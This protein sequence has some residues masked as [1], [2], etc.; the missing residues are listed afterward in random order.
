VYA[1]IHIHTGNEYM[2]TIFVYIHLFGCTVFFHIHST[3]IHSTYS[4]QYISNPSHVNEQ[5]FLASLSLDILT[6]WRAHTLKGPPYSPPKKFSI[7]ETKTT[8]QCFTDYQPR[9]KNSLAGSSE[10][11]QVI[12]T[13]W[14]KS[15]LYSGQVQLSSPF[16]HGPKSWPSSTRRVWI[17][18]LRKV[19]GLS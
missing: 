11:H 14:I 6:R 12:Q 4:I 16:L 13:P 17:K 10:T 9:M 1:Y 18:P 3:Y 15:V 2:I 8:P 7:N 19:W 5:G